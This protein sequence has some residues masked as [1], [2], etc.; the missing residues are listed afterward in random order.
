[1][2]FFDFTRTRNYRNFMA[3]VYGIGASVVLIGALFKINHYPGADIA[4]IVGL[5]T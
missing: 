4:L 3:K 1:M 5:G 2:A